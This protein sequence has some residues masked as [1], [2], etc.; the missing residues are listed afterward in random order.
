MDYL[1][2]ILYRVLFPLREFAPRLA[3]LILRSLA[4]TVKLPRY[5]Q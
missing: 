4:E 1:L 5:M 2:G 3:Y